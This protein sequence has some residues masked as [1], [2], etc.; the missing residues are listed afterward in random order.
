MISGKYLKNMLT[1]FQI[2][3]TICNYYQTTP[4]AIRGKHTRSNLEPLQLCQYFSTLYTK[5]SQT[6]IGSYF[7]SRD[8]S[9]VTHSK[10]VVDNLYATDKTFKSIVDELASLFDV[11]ME[12]STKKQEKEKVV[13]NYNITVSFIN[14]APLPIL[15]QLLPIV[16]QKIFEKY[17]EKQKLI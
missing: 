6:T 15:I 8:H 7:G 11:L 16:S 12:V 10:K 2:E 14:S 5:A 17:N 3:N 9:S 1:L 4:E 13:E